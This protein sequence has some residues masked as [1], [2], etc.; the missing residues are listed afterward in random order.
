MSE[1]ANEGLSSPERARNHFEGIVQVFSAAREE[2]THHAGQSGKTP[3]LQE[4][5]PRPP[6]HVFSK[7]NDCVPAF[8][9]ASLPAEG[10]VQ[11]SHIR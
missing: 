8:R 9:P 2:R 5:H 3:W 4:A 11:T 7:T 6:A 10:F 1:Q